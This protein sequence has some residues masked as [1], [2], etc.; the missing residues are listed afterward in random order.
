MTQS[1]KCLQVIIQP[2]SDAV[3]VVRAQAIDVFRTP[4]LLPPASQPTLDINPDNDSARPVST[5]IARHTF[6]WVENI[7][8]SMPTSPHNPNFNV[9]VRNLRNDPWA[10]AMDNIHHVFLAISPPLSTSLSSPLLPDSSGSEIDEWD[11][12]ADGLNSLSLSE[13][14]A[15]RHRHTIYPSTFA[16]TRNPRGH[17]RC[18][19]VTLGPLGTYACI[20]PRPAG[21]RGLTAF[22]VHAQH[23][24]TSPSLPGIGGG[25]AGK[26][27][28]QLGKFGYEGGGSSGSSVNGRC[29][30]WN[31]NGEGEGFD[32]WTAM[33]YDEAL[34]RVALGSAYGR[35]TVLVV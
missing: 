6:G 34:G 35:V 31:V 32:Q 3:V 23:T 1:N 15:E 21:Y 4:T 18:P 27:G 25:G 29:L 8:L 13:E 12:L 24:Q 22:D 9:L 33:E 11:E 7:S 19:T 17:L 28:L 16:T 26:E 5:S 30:W 2:A 10:P 14:P 20:I